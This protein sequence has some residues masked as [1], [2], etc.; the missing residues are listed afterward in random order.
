MSEKGKKKVVKSFD[1]LATLL[2]DVIKD[3]SNEQ[4]KN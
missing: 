1:E 3:V 4:G 2:Q